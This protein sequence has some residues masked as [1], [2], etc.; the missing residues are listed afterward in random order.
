MI[1]EA[2]SNAERAEA[3]EL[4][5]AAGLPDPFGGKATPREVCAG[6]R[7]FCIRDAAGNLIGAYALDLN[8]FRAGL[9]AVLT[10]GAGR[11]AADLTDL[12]GEHAEAV[13]V[14]A[15]ADVLTLATARPG[16]VRK[17]TRRGWTVSGWTLRKPL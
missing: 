2:G 14:Y 5:N 12:I 13:A 8:R 4:L 3:L 15:G 10:A 17:L 1:R 6:S 11:A 7:L 16:L 9:E